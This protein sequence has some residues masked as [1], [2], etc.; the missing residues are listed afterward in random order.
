MPRKKK[1]ST[2][3][4][5]GG[6]SSSS[7]AAAERPSNDSPA[8]E[9]SAPAAEPIDAEDVTL[10]ADSAP[11]LPPRADDVSLLAELAAA[12]NEAEGGPPSP[13]QSLS[14]LPS[15]GS[16][17]GLIN[18]GDDDDDGFVP[19]DAAASPAIAS[20]QVEN[21]LRDQ[22]ALVDDD[23]GFIAGYDSQQASPPFNWSDV[24]P[25][26]QNGAS[27]IILSSPV[28]APSDANFLDDYDDEDVV[29]AE[30]VGTPFAV[31]EGDGEEADCTGMDGEGEEEEEEAPVM[32]EVI[33]TPFVMEEGDEIV[34]DDADDSLLDGPPSPFPPPIRTL[35]MEEL[36]TID[37]SNG[38]GHGDGGVA[39]EGA[40]G[41]EGSSGNGLNSARLALGE[42]KMPKTPEEEDTPTKSGRGQIGGIDP[43]QL[44]SPLGTEL[45]HRKV[46]FQQGPPGPS[47]ESEQASKGVVNDPNQRSSPFSTE[48]L[49]RKVAFQS[50]GGVDPNQLTSPLGTALLQKKMARQGGGFG[51]ELQVSQGPDSE[52]SADAISRGGSLASISEMMA[53]GV[54][55]ESES[56]SKG[57]SPPLRGLTPA[58]EEA[59]EAEEAFE[60]QAGLFVAKVVDGA[61]TEAA[62]F[63]AAAAASSED[64]PTR[65]T[66]MPSSRSMNRP[67][68]S[69]MTEVTS[70]AHE[71]TASLDGEDGYGVDNTRVIQEDMKTVRE[72][73][74]AQQQGVDLAALSAASEGSPA[75]FRIPLTPGGQHDLSTLTSPMGHALMQKKMARQG[76]AWGSEAQP[77]SSPMGHALL[78]KKMARQQGG[79]WSLRG[80]GADSPAELT[81]PMGHALMAKKMARQGGAPWGSEVAQGGAS[82][83]TSDLTSPMGADLMKKKMARQSGGWGSE[84]KSSPLS[85]LSATE[86]QTDLASQLAS[87]SDDPFASAS[88]PAAG[89]PFESAPSNP[90][91]APSPA[92][93]P[94]AQNPFG[95]GNPF[96]A[97]KSDNPFDGAPSNPFGAPSNPFGDS[98]DPFAS[99]S[100]DDPFTTTAPEAP[101]ASEA[102]A[103]GKEAA[104]LEEE[105]EEGEDDTM[106]E[107][108]LEAIRADCFAEEVSLPPLEISRRWS[109]EQARAYFENGGDL[110]AVPGLDTSKIKPALLK[111]ELT[112]LTITATSSCFTKTPTLSVKSVPVTTGA[113]SA[114][115]G[116]AGG[117]AAAEEEEPF[118]MVEALT[119]AEAEEAD[120]ITNEAPAPADAEAPEE[121][122]PLSKHPVTLEDDEND[123]NTFSALKPHKRSSTAPF[124]AETSAF[125]EMGGEDEDG[126]EDEVEGAPAEYAADF[127]ARTSFA[128]GFDD[129]GAFAPAPTESTSTNPFEEPS[130]GGG[131]GGGF[132]ESFDAAFDDS[133]VSPNPFGAPES[134]PT[135]AAKKAPP[136][137]PPPKAPPPPPPPPPEG[138]EGVYKPAEVKSPPPPPPKPLATSPP[139]TGRSDS[140]STIDGSPRRSGSWAWRAEQSGVQTNTYVKTLETADDII[141][142]GWSLKKGGL[143]KKSRY[144]ALTKSQEVRSN[145]YLQRSHARTNT[146]TQPT[147]LIRHHT[148]S[149]F[150]CAR[151]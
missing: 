48:L 85:T 116:A 50:K 42:L 141:F 134:A 94:A 129:G 61:M 107:E 14:N 100:A 34:G 38:E 52:S 139:T 98:G 90:F 92:S 45:L 95:S 16:A 73:R 65:P 30:V 7:S 24:T 51:A 20:I 26:G 1:R 118:E 25:G 2:G 43:N 130:E 19:S 114:N 55:W 28:A 67:R 109:E 124:R 70:M 110:N 17:T 15:V 83:D 4:G 76:G 145:C 150:F 33:S 120:A 117:S 40:G 104:A 125:G 9:V 75:V 69:A 101:A 36:E 22:A 39:T 5:G 133:A 126:L 142:C 46:A 86:S 37:A 31:E 102:L 105:D 138:H 29:E 13:S 136:P 59:A 89:N 6:G 88:S 119:P 132:A 47:D 149:P 53:G 122:T 3:G 112:S 23:A 81:S 77:M 56:G 12:A 54:D 93:S 97:S 74:L 131:G 11:P 49:H 66:M 58:L 147:T 127:A 108:L 140:P 32:A 21:L 84:V 143:F 41:G 60:L 123:G 44:S 82:E 103:A 135:A 113:A 27:E 148:L 63:D 8:E 18:F 64:G 96:S 68:P 151:C 72:M 106:D 10:A 87:A 111:K 71:I 137:P 99:T 146:S 121:L 62:R 78:A 144:F 79:G 57:G 115:M 128:D 91:G 35:S 80:D